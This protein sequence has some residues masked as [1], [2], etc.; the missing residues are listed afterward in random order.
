MRRSRHLRRPEPRRAG[1]RIALSAAALSVLGAVISSSVIGTALVST[2]AATTSPLYGGGYLMAADPGGGY[3]TATNDGSVTAHGG[4]P[5]LGSPALSGLH[6]SQPIVGMAATPDGGGYWLVASDGGVFSY[7]DAS[8]Y[9]STG[10]I[11]LNRPIVGMAATPNGKGYWLVASDGGIFTYGDASFYGSAGALPLKQPVVGMATTPDGKGYWLVA[12]DGGIFTYGDASFYGSTGAI[13]LNKPIIGMA[14]T[15]DGQGYWLVASDGGVFTFGDAKFSGST[16]GGFTTVLGIVI[17]PSSTTGYTLVAT[18]GNDIVPTLTPIPGGVARGSMLDGVYAGAANPAGVAAFDA[19]TGT[20]SQIATD[21]LP[22]DS[23]WSG[24]DGAGGSLSWLTSAWDGTG[25][26]LSLGVPIIPANSGGTLAAGAAGA[27]NSYF[28]TLAQTLVAGGEGNAYLRLGWEFDGNWSPSWDAQTPSAEA[29]FAAYFD[30]IVTAM[31]SVPGERFEFV[32]NPDA[33]AFTQAGYNVA[34]AYPGNAYVNVIGLD[35][36]DTTWVTPQTPANA[37]NEATLP[38]LTAARAFAA[39]HGIPLAICE[40]G[41]AFLTDGHGLGDDPLYVNN[42]SAWMQN[43]A[44]A[45]VYES[46]F[47]YNGTGDSI[48]DSGATP[49]SLAAFKTDFG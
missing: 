8:F 38:A 22:S 3:W 27:Y 4:A 10:A 44:N 29:E 43:P 12:S 14:R 32:W 23:G 35:A 47:N 41:I 2:N 42:I 36:Y 6:L 15:P 37:W 16:G 20:Q 1:R 13:A 39:A 46:Y 18:N 30:Q 48:L 40:W 25:Y 34:L 19:A 17:S 9:G 11:H 5:T 24:M 26:T 31:R 7:G 28:V 45:V 49:N 21:Y 33:S